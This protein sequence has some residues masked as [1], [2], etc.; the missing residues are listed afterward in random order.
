MTQLSE[1]E[2]MFQGTVRD[3]AEQEIRPRVIVGK[4]AFRGPDDESQ[5]GE[6]RPRRVRRPQ[7]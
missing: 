6:T 3:F 7:V 4:V 2:R 5:D 1:E